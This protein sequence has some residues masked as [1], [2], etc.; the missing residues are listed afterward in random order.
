M[1]AKY[2][3]ISA[4]LSPAP[5]APPA[6]RGG[7]LVGDAPGGSVGKLKHIEAIRQLKYRYMRCLD[8]KLWDEM[9][10]VFSDDA[11]SSYDKGRY[12]STGPTRSSAS[13]ARRSTGPAWSACTRCTIRRSS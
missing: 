3:R 4:L 6:L 8:S 10:E 7:I 1:R 9:R 5:I 11:I 13:C 2:S 12:T